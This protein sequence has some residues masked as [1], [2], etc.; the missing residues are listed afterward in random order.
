MERNSDKR[1]RVPSTEQMMSWI[2]LIFNQGIRRPGYPADYWVENWIKEQFESFGFKDIILD[3]IEAKKWEAK[4]EILEIWLEKSPKEIKKIPCFPIPYTDASKTVEASLEKNEKEKSL[5]GKIALTDITLFNVPLK[6]LRFLT[7]ADRV[8]DPLNEFETLNQL[9]PFD[10]RFQNVL[11]PV[12]EKGAIGAIGILSG[13]PWN[14]D[15]YYVPY[16]AVKRAI[17]GVY[18]SP[19]NGKGISAL[20]EKGPAKARIS[21]AGLE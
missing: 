5:N 14:T 21:Y 16:D 2:K 19:E 15:K 10:V 3:P 11:E 4:D 13:Y 20:M 18:V 8:H 12:I 17:P 1:D 9:V 7:G 6:M